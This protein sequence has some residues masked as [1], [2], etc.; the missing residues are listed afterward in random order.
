MPDDENLALISDL[1]SEVEELRS[2]VD[3]A[4][5]ALLRVWG[6]LDD[7][8]RKLPDDERD[9][10]ADDLDRLHELAHLML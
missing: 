1:S 6:V 10:Y 5:E 4:R 7:L 2:R 3:M 8:V 9:E